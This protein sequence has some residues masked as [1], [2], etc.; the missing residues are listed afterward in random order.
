MTATQ[1]PWD[2]GLDSPYARKVAES[3]TPGQLVSL[4]GAA[5]M[6]EVALT[7]VKYAMTVL[8]PI[9]ETHHRAIVEA[10]EEWPLEDAVYDALR[11]RTPYGRAIDAAISLQEAVKTV[12]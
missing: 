5:D 4:E 1:A 3:I 6:L 2:D 11:D 7:M 12:C 8:G 9:V 10:P